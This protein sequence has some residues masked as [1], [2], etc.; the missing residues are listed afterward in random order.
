M[1][2]LN[3]SRVILA[4]AAALAFAAPAW[5][6]EFFIDLGNEKGGRSLTAL[7]GFSGDSAITDS[8][9][10]VNYDP[11]QI[12]VT[13]KAL[14]SAGCSNPRP[15]LIRVVSP[16]LGGKVLGEKVGAYCQIVATALNGKTL[17]PSAGLLS[18]Q[19]P[20]CS[21]EGGAAKSCSAENTSA[22]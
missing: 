3:A 11:A 9:V 14:G 18:L 12:S 20:F 5:S 10:D 7:V 8:Q 13:V 17:G 19:N 15:G 4:A 21:G 22:K 2:R 6:A 16:D 1:S